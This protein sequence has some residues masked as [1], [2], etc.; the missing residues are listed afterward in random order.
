[1]N[2]ALEHDADILD[3]FTR[4]ALPFAQR[5]ASDGEMLRL[6][7]E[8]SGVGPDDR[9]L[10]IACGPGLVSCA[11]A[12]K[13][14]QVTGLDMVPAMLER[15]R[16]LQGE[17]GHVNIDWRQGTATALPFAEGIFD[18]VIT[19]FSFHHYLD[20]AAALRE[21][22]RVC[23]PSGTLMVADVTPR[24]DA[25]KAYNEVEKL[26]DPSHTRALTEAEFEALGRV[27]GM[28]L[29]RKITY[30]LESDLEGL[31]EASFPLP[32]DSDK[33]RDQF[34]N[35][36][37]KGTDHLG[38]EAHRRNGQIYFFFPITAFVWQMP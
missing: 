32:G 15:A 13:V 25:Q 2:K 4:Q 37:D 7:V 17:Q 23:K 34:R 36:L 33:V 28:K 18:A 24:A 1:M 35:D 16:I 27:S 22:K 3:Q 21:M 19:R 29:L 5:H 31:L 8:A 14:R 26:R 20:P 30:R 6:L 10:D 9:I 12:A 38:V 11:F